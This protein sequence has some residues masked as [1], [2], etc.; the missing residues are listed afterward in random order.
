VAALLLSMLLQLE[1]DGHIV[2]LQSYPAMEAF[3]KDYT[4]WF[5]EFIESY[6]EDTHRPYM[7]KNY[8]EYGNRLKALWTERPKRDYEK[9]PFYL[10]GKTLERTNI[11]E[12]IFHEMI[13]LRVE[14][15]TSELLEITPEN[16]F[17]N[18]KNIKNFEGS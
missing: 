2:N 4:H 8:V 5:D 11:S 1:S 13:E 10:V 6:Y 3:E 7:A 12:E 16:G 17:L 14:D 9:L 18:K 15:V